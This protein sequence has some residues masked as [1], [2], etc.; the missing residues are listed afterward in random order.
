MLSDIKETC[1]VEVLTVSSPR[2]T[3]SETS[4]YTNTA[5][6][7]IEVSKRPDWKGLIIFQKSSMTC[8]VEI[9]RY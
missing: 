3:R 4:Q 8:V 6:A 7:A 2:V 5:A 1:R 9:T